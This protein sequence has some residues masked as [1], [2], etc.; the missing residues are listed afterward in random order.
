LVGFY[1]ISLNPS[2]ITSNYLQKE[3]WISFKP[4]LK[5]LAHTETILLLLLTQHW[6]HKL[7]KIQCTIR[8]SFKMLWT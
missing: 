1:F 7:V 8:L 5:V 2:L 3:F 6:E 4:F